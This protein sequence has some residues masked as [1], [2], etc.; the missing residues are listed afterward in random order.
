ME[1]I[2]VMVVDN[3]PNDEIITMKALQ[4]NNI[5][6]QIIKMQDGVTAL[7]YLIQGR[8]IPDGEGPH[9]PG[10]LLLD[11][12]MPGMAGMEVLTRLRAEEKTTSLPVVI[13]TSSTD[14]R[15]I[16]ACFAAG[17]NG[18]LHKSVRFDEF[19]KNMGEIVSK[20]IK[21]YAAALQGAPG[22]C[23]PEITDVGNCA[24]LNLL[25]SG[26]DTCGEYG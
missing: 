12:N 20:C 23:F 25:E 3:D 13:T 4:L 15:E 11:L 9:V 17:A 24:A 6:S 8:E 26:I 19:V 10:L 22:Q 18:Y 14:H 21:G 2:R 7:E 1:N 5:G 16:S